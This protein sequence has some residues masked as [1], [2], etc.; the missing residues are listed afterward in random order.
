VLAALSLTLGTA[1]CSGSDD[2]AGGSAD[3]ELADG[4][5]ATAGTVATGAEGTM[6][7][8]SEAPADDQEGGELAASGTGVEAGPLELAG[9]LD[10]RQI[11]VEATATLR[12]DDVRAAVDGITAAATAQDGMVAS[13]D[14]DYAP[15]VARPD[16][17][18][19]RATIVVKVPPASLSTVVERLADFGTV[20]G[21]DQ[22]AEDVT[23]RLTDLDTRI[24]NQRQSIARL[25]GLLAEAANVDVLLKVEARLSDAELELEQLLAGERNLDARVQMSTLTVDVVAIVPGELVAASTEIEPDPDIVEALSA[26]WT[27]F[28][29]VLFT[30]VFGLAAAAPFIVLA[31]VAAVVVF[32]VRRALTQRRLERPEMGPPSDDP[33]NRRDVVSA[34]RSE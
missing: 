13:A 9:P 11:A 28:V 17:P 22:L 25:R 16:E 26:G 2:E 21:F 23:E 8:G 33:A 19:S 32:T 31:L 5:E 10:D 14:V 34:S 18:T 24:D 3:T 27:A 29:G 7:P 30:I 1:A 4:A 20:T 15:E 12:T 6:S